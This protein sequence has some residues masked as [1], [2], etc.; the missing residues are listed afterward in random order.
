MVLVHLLDWKGFQG[1]R[2]GGVGELVLQTRLSGCRING[3][4]MAEV[5]C[6]Q[7]GD[8]RRKP[9]SPFSEKITTA[10]DCFV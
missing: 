6:E 5:T 7:I 1:G 4:V 2:C 8:V 9:S 10:D 3:F